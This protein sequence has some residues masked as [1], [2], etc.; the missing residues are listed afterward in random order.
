MGTISARKI[1]DALA[2]ARNVGLVEERFTI[3]DCEVVLRNLRP[4]EYTACI[5]ECKELEDAAFM[6]AYQK[7]HI[8]RSIIEI[9]GVDLR[10]VDFVEVEEDDPKKPGS[11]KTVKLELHKYVLS[12]VIVSWG[13]E[14][15]TVAFRKFGDV[16][17]LAEKKAKEGITFVLPEETA[18]EKLRRLLG[19]IKELEDEIPPTL[20]EKVLDEYGLMSKST[21]EEAKAAM[22]RADQ[23]AREAEARNEAPPEPPPAAAPPPHPAAPPP[24][25]PPVASAPQTA[26]Q[27]APAGSTPDEIMRSRQPL[28]RQPLPVDPHKVLQDRV[29]QAQANAPPVAR[30]S[31]TAEI[32]ALQADAGAAA[33]ADAPPTSLPTHL[34]GPGGIPIPVVQ[35]AQP[36]EIAELATKGQDRVD[37]KALAQALDR[38]PPAG[39]NPRYKPPP[40]M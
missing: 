18:D 4:D 13:K 17:S 21:A 20:L 2:K 27:A 12:H 6:Y 19:E 3:F 9:N 28:N 8:C 23:L 34:T 7:A 10:D 38:P 37:P 25:A 1:T 15:I 24:P 33:I 16:Q 11:T 32:A 39:I 29:A 40:R 31:R 5:D 30:S 26:P 22:E 35:P 14:A 36:G